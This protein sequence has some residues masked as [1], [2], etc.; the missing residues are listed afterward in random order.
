MTDE[1]RAEFEQKYGKAISDYLVN[2]SLGQVMKGD[3]EYLGENPLYLINL[4]LKASQY[5][6]EKLDERS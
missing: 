1:V 6:W 5:L 3:K 4:L 2:M